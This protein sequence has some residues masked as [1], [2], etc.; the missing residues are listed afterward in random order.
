MNRNLEEQKIKQ[1]FRELRQQDE[2]RA[3][4]FAAISNPVPLKTGGFEGRF[5]NWRLAGAAILL[6]FALIPVLFMF[7]HTS[8]P[9]PGKE[10]IASYELIHKLPDYQ[11]AH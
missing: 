8:A 2:R 4:S 5:G 7:N 6:L 10:L 11:S 1:L 9:L 3:P